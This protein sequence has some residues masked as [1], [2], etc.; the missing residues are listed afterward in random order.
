MPKKEPKIQQDL[1]IPLTG[2]GDNQNMKVSIHEDGTD[3]PPRVTLDEERV[4]G[5]TL[6]L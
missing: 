2:A 1:N 3:S 6:E 4:E 5:E